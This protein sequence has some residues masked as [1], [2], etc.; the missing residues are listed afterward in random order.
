MLPAG[1]GMWSILE[2]TPRPQAAAETGLVSIPLPMS[3]EPGL[4]VRD[5]IGGQL[6]T[7]S[8]PG[9]ASHWQLHFD[10]LADRQSWNV[11]TGWQLKPHTAAA[12]WTI[13]GR[14][15]EKRLDL[16]LTQT[17]TGWTGLINISPT[18]QKDDP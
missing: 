15:G 12:V 17:G 8:G 13:P 18:R 7:F 9:P 3:A 2:V 14:E 16:R 6:I 5:E 11:E 4:A 1:E 10:Q